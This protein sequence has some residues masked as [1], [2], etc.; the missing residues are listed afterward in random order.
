MLEEPQQRT[1][2][3]KDDSARGNGSWEERMPN[4][5]V[6]LCRR[7]KYVLGDSFSMLSADEATRTV[8]LSGE[9]FANDVPVSRVGK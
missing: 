2:K 8:T 4:P 7:C 1:A 5:L 6:F 9:Y 3:P